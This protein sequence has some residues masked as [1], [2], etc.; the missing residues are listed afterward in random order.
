MDIGEEKRSNLE[1]QTSNFRTAL[2]GFEKLVERV[3]AQKRDERA[4]L[5]IQKEDATDYD[6]F[7]AAVQELFGPEVKN[8]DVKCFYRKLCNNP[9]A[10]IDWCEVLIFH[11]YIIKS[12]GMKN[13]AQEDLWEMDTVHVYTC[14]LGFQIF[15]YFASEKDSLTSQMDEENLVFLVSRKQRVVI[16]GSRR[17]DVIKGIVKVPQLDLLI[18]A[19]Q[20]GLI[21]IFNGQVI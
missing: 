12:R 5:F 10:S 6:K 9:E 8:Q 18:T 7:Y 3:A 20:K 14:C 13:F 11:V 19:S 15:G 21:T 16:S 1:V 2:K 4:G 17:R